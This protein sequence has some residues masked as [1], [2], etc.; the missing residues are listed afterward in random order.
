MSTLIAI[1]R[2]PVEQ[3]TTEID[4]RWRRG[5]VVAVL[6]LAVAV[7]VAG[8]PALV[9]GAERMFGTDLGAGRRRY[10]RWQVPAAALLGAFPVA[11]GR[12]SP[13]PSSPVAT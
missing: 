7:F 5:L 4:P 11:A 13:S 8:T 6:A 10:R 3:F 12:S 1:G 2:R 9:H